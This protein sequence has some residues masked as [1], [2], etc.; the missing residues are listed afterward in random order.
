M[1]D[2]VTQAPC[3]VRM[4]LRLSE[5][6]LGGVLVTILI[7][8]FDRD[9]FRGWKLELD[10]KVAR[11][12]VANSVPTGRSPGSKQVESQSSGTTFQVFALFVIAIFNRAQLFQKS[13]SYSEFL[14]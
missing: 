3:H 10:R 11:S 2:F 14:C 5:G 4:D 12:S 7:E 1:C 13:I 9:V 6:D 8:N